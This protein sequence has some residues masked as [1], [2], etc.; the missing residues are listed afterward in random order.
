M[1]GRLIMLINSVT[2]MHFSPVGT[3]KK[4]IESIV[5]GMGT[6]D[7]EIIDLT[8]PEVRDEDMPSIH[9]DVVL[10]GVPVYEEKIPEILYPYFAGLKGN[11][12]PVVLAGVYGDASD[13]IALRELGLIMRNTGFKVVAADSFIGEHSCSTDKI[14][15][16]KDRP[17]KEDLNE[18]E[19]FGKSI[20]KKMQNINSL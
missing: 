7:R 15:F 11:G 20:I 16:A 8:L 14:P 5:K 12:K 10:I 4:I 17:D 3:T 1:R 6:A 2:V 19:E 9:G 13:S 18:A